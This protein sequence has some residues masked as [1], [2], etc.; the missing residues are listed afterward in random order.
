M[1]TS[2]TV[3]SC[4]IKVLGTVE[5]IISIITKNTVRLGTECTCSTGRKISPNTLRAIIYCLARFAIYWAL[6][7]VSIIFIIAHN[8]VQAII[9]IVA[10]DTVV[11]RE[12]SDTCIRVI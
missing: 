8:T 2:H 3:S 5:A 12:A 4:C 11:D 1:N 7:A 10:K 6:K 9:S